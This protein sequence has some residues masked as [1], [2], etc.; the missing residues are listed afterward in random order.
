MLR[1]LVAV[2]NAV[3]D[4]PPQCLNMSKKKAKATAT[5]TCDWCAS[6]KLYCLCQTPYDDQLYVAPRAHPPALLYPG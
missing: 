1:L 6:E 5:Y 4:R 2:I 3:T